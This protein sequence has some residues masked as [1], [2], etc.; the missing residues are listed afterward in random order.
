M[1]DALSERSPKQRL[2]LIDVARGTALLAMAIYHFTW[3]L[4]FFGYVSPGLTTEGGWKLFARLIAGSFLF[5]VG[6]SL[7]L[8]HSNGI[9]WRS[10]GKRLLMIAAAAL[11]ITIATRFATPDRY[12]FF[13]I[14]HCIA[15]SS[16]LGLAF[17]RLPPI[18]TAIA[19][20]AAMLAPYYLASG[21][22]SQN[23]L[24]WLGLSSEPV[25]SNDYVPILPWFG[26][27]LFGIA[28]ARAGQAFGLFAWIASID[29]R[30]IAVEK[31]LAFAG[32]HSLAVYLIHQPVLIGLVYLASIAIPAPAA[33]PAANFSASCNS[34][35][36]SENPADFCNRFC[37]CTL[38]ELRNAG[39]LETLLTS[40]ADV[41]L[42]PGV[43]EIVNACTASVLE[44]NRAE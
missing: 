40:E 38:G 23:W 27:V 16:L 21:F 26:P 44:G 31:P 1:T 28:A 41:G 24:L 43:T 32:R 8:G 6:I 35:C 9:R 22:F 39:L 2:A 19:G 25:R 29:R 4:E 36:A 5:L 20:L 18:V 37:E 13:G 34:S 3:D 42:T 30:Q 15:A 11:A 10:F 7:V 12:I 14:L 17:L 33:D